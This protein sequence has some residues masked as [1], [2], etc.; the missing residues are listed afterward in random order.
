MA[1]IVRDRE[2]IPS[3]PNVTLVQGIGRT[4]V[5]VRV[6]SRD[7]PAGKSGGFRLLICHCAGDE[8]ARVLVY[9]KTDQENAPKAT[10]LAAITAERL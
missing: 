6:A 10:I 7:I 4:I 5:K 9:A 1:E 2:P 3:P 8:W